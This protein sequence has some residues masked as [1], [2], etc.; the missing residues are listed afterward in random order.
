MGILWRTFLSEIYKILLEDWGLLYLQPIEIYIQIG[1]HCVQNVLFLCNHFIF[2]LITPS[3][4][5][6][7]C[8]QIKDRTQCLVFTSI[9]QA[10]AYIFYLCLNISKKVSIC[11]ICCI[12]IAISTLLNYSSDNYRNITSTVCPQ[13][14]AS[15]GPSHRC[16]RYKLV[17][18]LS[19]SENTTT[20]FLICIRYNFLF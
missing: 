8:E 10:C 4:R 13:S 12:Y 7:L 20:F 17:I 1:N 2:L 19:R 6:T 18:V 14:V 5:N 15:P 9:N 16:H 3:A 11:C